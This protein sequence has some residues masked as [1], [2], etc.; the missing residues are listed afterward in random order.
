MIH[1]W[2]LSVVVITF[3]RGSK[4]HYLRSWESGLGRAASYSLL[5]TLLGWWGFPFGLVNTPLT[6]WRNGRGGTDV[7]AEMLAQ[8]LGPGR[9]QSVLTQA[10]PRKVDGRHWL[11][12][13]LC[14][15]LPALL[16]GALFSSLP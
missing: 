4:V 10:N 5:S 12:F 13:F 9:A 11:L 2:C 16:V 7:T 1:H 6:L 8:I 3:T 15:A 14:L